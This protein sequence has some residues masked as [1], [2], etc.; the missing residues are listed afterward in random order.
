MTETKWAVRHEGGCNA[1]LN[2]FTLHA[3]R[4]MA[5]IRKKKCTDPS[6]KVVRVEVRVVEVVL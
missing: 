3:N 5:E 1:S 2:G 4:T 6:C